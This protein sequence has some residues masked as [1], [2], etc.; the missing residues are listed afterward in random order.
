M[1]QHSFDLGPYVW[2]VRNSVSDLSCGKTVFRLGILS[3]ESP[4][5][6]VFGD[7]GRPRGPGRHSR[8]V[9]GEAPHISGYTRV[10]PVRDIPEFDPDGATYQI[11]RSHL[12]SKP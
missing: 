10:T 4:G 6:P 7:S 2:K 12:G 8:K 9:R 5:N 3:L 1:E 11:S